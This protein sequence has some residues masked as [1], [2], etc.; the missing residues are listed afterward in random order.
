MKFNEEII[1]QVKNIPPEVLEMHGVI[2]VAKAVI[3]GKPTYICPHC[4]NGTGKD[5]TGIQP[6][7]FNGVW[8]YHCF[9]CNEA[10]DNI[11]LLAIHYNL[12]SQSDFFV[13]LLMNFPFA[14]YLK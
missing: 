12:D 5:G 2:S 14:I 3:N 9:K 4:D 1:I 6:A 11:K 13:A 7:Y 10:F 8:L